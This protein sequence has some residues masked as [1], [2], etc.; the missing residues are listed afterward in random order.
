MK[1]IISIFALALSGAFAVSAGADAAEVGNPPAFFQQAAAV[2]GPL[3]A[4]VP[5]DDQRE[6]IQPPS[7]IDPGMT[8]DPPQT[9]AKMPIFHPPDMPVSRFILP[10]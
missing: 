6:V 1:Q 2:A 5:I 9:G 7:S 3:V 4:F 8:L 10:R